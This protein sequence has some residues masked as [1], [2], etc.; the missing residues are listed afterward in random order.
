LAIIV[1]YL[2]LVL[3]IGLYLEDQPTRAKTFYRRT[4][5]D[6]LGL[7]PGVS[8]GESGSLELTGSAGN[9]YRYGILAAH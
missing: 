4:R 7:G 8:V 5:D 9:A 6:G 3:A 2:A 1:F